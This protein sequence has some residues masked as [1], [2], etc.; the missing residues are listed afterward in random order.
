MS[1]D[2]SAPP[3]VLLDFFTPTISDVLR[4]DRKLAEAGSTI[5]LDEEIRN[6]LSVFDRMARRLADTVEEA[7][8]AGKQRADAE[9]AKLAVIAWIDDLLERHS[10]W[11]SQEQRLQRQVYSGSADLGT[12]FTEKVGELT[13]DQPEVAEVFLTLLG[14]DFKGGYAVIDGQRK[15]LEAQRLLKDKL[16]DRLVSLRADAQITPQPFQMDDPVPAKRSSS[17]WKLWVAAG[18]AAAVVVGVIAAVLLRLEPTPQG[19][20]IAEA[21]AAATAVAEGFEC[22]KL[23]VEVVERQSGGTAGAAG[24]FLA[25][26][27]GRLASTADQSRLEQDL[28]E[29]AG[30]EQ[31]DLGQVAVWPRPFCAALDLLEDGSLVTTGTAEGPDITLN[32]TGE[33]PIYH[34][35]DN[36][37][38]EVAPPVN[39]GHLYI[40]YFNM[41]GDIFPILPGVAGDETEVTG[42]KPITVGVP[43]DETPT[44]DN[45]PILVAAEDPDEFGMLM[46]FFTPEPLWRDGSV[47]EKAEPYLEKVRAG[48]QS[49]T[50][51]DT[52]VSNLLAD[53]VILD[54][55][56]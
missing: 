7:V 3:R 51:A 35:G 9:L 6:P 5:G 15:R 55:R 36:V 48:L 34:D 52:P 22:A 28:A 32:R 31:T 2:V 17:K 13:G 49:L 38:I 50:E 11:M 54:L 8:A 40:A 53:Y 29:I 25:R 39:N 33:M 10:F 30:V 4:L 56:P 37:Y 47:P 44:Q 19:P 21:R 24:G 42:V 12:R 43:D 26:A 41:Q 46:A 45:P 18:V 23:T 14:L 27:S 20:S 1:I 16:R